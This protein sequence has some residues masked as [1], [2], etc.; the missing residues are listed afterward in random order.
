MYGKFVHESHVIN[1]FTEHVRIEKFTPCV[2]EIIIFFSDFS[3]VYIDGIIIKNHFQQLMIRFLM[4]KTFVIMIPLIRI[5][6]HKID[7]LLNYIV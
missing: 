6:H 5:V 7:H 2:L 1:I 4:K 3:L